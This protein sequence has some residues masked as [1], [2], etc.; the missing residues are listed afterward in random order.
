MYAF[1]TPLI[2]IREMSVSHAIATID[3]IKRLLTYSGAIIRSVADAAGM[4]AATINITEAKSML[5]P[6]MKPAKDPNIADTHA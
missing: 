1:F 3:V 2:T 5:Q 4:D 6:V